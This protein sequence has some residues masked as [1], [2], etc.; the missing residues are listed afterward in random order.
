MSDDRLPKELDCTNVAKEWRAWKSEFLMYMRAT[1]KANGSESTKLATFLWLIGRQARDIYNTLFPNDGT[2]NGILG[3]EIVVAPVGGENADQNQNVAVAVANQRT[4]KD[5]L[6]AFDGYCIPKK[7]TTMESFKFNNILQKERQP[8]AEFETEI[9]KQIQFCE[10]NCKCDCGKELKYEERML[11]DR[12]I[13]GIH[14]KKLQLKLLDGKDEP[15]QKVIEMCKSYEAA[16]ENKVM[17]N[18]NIQPNVNSVAEQQPKETINAVTRRCY[19]CGNDFTANH[20]QICKARDINCRSCGRKGHFQRF[21]K[22]K[23]IKSESNNVYRKPNNNNNNINQKQQHSLN[24]EGTGNVVQIIDE[25]ANRLIKVDRIYRINSNNVGNHKRRWY[26]EYQIADQVVKFKLDTG[27]DVD[28]IP[29]KILK[30]LKVSL[31]NKKENYSV[32]D[33]NGNKVNV[34]GTV[35][36]KCVDRKLKTEQSSHFIVVDDVCEPIL[37][38]ESCER[39]GLV[40]RTDV[41]SVAW[42]SQTKEEFVQ[43]NRDVFGGLGKFP[44]KFSIN[45]KENSKPVLHYKKRIPQSLLNRLKLQLDKMARE[46]IISPVDYPTDWVN[47]LQIVEKPNSSELRI[48]L[49]PKPLNECIKREHF[50]IPTIDD[51]TSGLANKRVFSVLDLKTGYWQMELDEASSDLTT[52]MTPFGRFKFVRVPFGLNFVPELFQREMIRMF[53][54]IEGV[55]IY[56]DDMGICAENEKEHDR[57]MDKVME[58]ARINNIK[59][60]PDKIQY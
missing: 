8:F 41:S 44:G 38:L 35:E 37:G 40:K 33:Y 1:G 46:G 31:E 2:E 11:K 27:S 45:L 42:L 51:L 53:G 29:L 48:C 17:L 15:L 18:T 20:L 32:F 19:N 7:N 58:R 54:D 16:N 22:S 4:L 21:C 13:I 43:S 56:F 9:R 28:C 52:F 25:S 39:F 3:E 10:F 36:L 50:L 14:D 59:F 24:W 60:N 34:F 49:D 55:I 5:V 23:G 12:I 57:I 6:L 30:T 26:K 47:N